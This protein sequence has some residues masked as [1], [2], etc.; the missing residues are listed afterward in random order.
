M[1]VGSEINANI[2][3]RRPTS[4]STSRLSTS[5]QCYFYAVCAI[6]AVCHLCMQCVCSPFCSCGPDPD[7]GTLS[8]VIVQPLLN[9]GCCDTEQSTA[10]VHG[11]LTTVL[12]CTF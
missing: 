3:G 11:G 2:S 9:L 8:F 4:R 10:M 7:H 6:C 5:Y 1:T 12:R